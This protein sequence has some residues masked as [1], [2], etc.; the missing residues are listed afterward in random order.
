MH[1]QCMHTCHTHAYFKAWSFLLRLKKW[2]LKWERFSRLFKRTDRGSMT[3]RELGSSSW[4]LGEKECWLLNL[5]WQNGILTL[6]CYIISMVKIA[7]YASLI[8]MNPINQNSLRSNFHDSFRWICGGT[9]Q[10]YYL[11]WWMQSVLGNV[12]LLLTIPFSNTFS[13]LKGQFH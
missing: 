1:T 11:T 10:V 9:Q 5:A 4:S 7:S 2:F 6:R 12:E 3:N 13:F 8:I